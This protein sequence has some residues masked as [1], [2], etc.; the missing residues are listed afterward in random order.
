[1]ATEQGVEGI[2]NVVLY[3]AQLFKNRSDFTSYEALHGISLSLIL[4][5]AI[6]IQARVFNDFLVMLGNERITCTEELLA[7]FPLK[8]RAFSDISAMLCR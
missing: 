8:G 1:M 4:K 7:P 6:S 3:L 5:A 2:M